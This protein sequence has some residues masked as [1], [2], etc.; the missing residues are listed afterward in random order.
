MLW[1]P[2]NIELWH[3]HFED[4]LNQQGLSTYTYFTDGTLEH[5]LNMIDAINPN[6]Y[7]ILGGK[8]SNNTNHVVI[9][10][11]GAIV[12]DPAIDN[13]GIVGPLDHGFFQVTVLIPLFLKQ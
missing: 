6:V 9:V 10:K 8:S 3:Q 12:W 11:D 7:V 1:K 13:S 2:E 4:Y 5:V